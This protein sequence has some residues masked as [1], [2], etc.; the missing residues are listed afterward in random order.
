MS[1][2]VALVAVFFALVAL[3]AVIAGTLVR[4]MFRYSWSSRGQDDPA[5][6]RQLSAQRRHSSARRRMT[7]S[8]PSTDSHDS[9]HRSQASAQTPHTSA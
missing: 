3:A 4:P 8:L 9:A 2:A 7:S 6:S 1:T 5:I